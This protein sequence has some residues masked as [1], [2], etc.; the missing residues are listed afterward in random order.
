MGEATERYRGSLDEPSWGAR[1][2]LIL[3]TGYKGASRLE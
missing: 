1:E 3:T 2:G